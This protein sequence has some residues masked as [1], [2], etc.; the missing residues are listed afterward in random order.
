MA[1][2]RPSPRDSSPVTVAPL[3]C[4]NC[5]GSFQEGDLACPWCNAGIALEDRDD[6]AAFVVRDTGVGI[7]AADLP[8]SL[9]HI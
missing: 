1:S 3:R 5:G 6:H 8:L 9:I 2:D 7:A 4:G